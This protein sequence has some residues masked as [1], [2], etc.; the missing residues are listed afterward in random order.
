MR[1]LLTVITNYFL[2]RGNTL[3]LWLVFFSNKNRDLF[4]DKVKRKHK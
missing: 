2:Y 3:I 1:L 4:D